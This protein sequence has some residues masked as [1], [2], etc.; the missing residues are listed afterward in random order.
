MEINAR[1]RQVLINVG[2]IIESC[3]WP[4]K[5]SLE[6]SSDVYDKLWRFDREGLPADLIS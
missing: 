4:G 6:L 3:F 2:G 5:Y 1:A